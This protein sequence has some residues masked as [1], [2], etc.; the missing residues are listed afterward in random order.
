MWH[1]LSE[2]STSS[3]TVSWSCEGS[4]ARGAM[5]AKV[6]FNHMQTFPYAQIELYMYAYVYVYQID[7]KHLMLGSCLTTSFD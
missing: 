6:N 7:M 5:Q 4:Q 3:S 2:E 1:I